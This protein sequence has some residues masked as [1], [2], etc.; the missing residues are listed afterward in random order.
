MSGVTGITTCSLNE[1]INLSV[2]QT[3]GTES[4]EHLGLGRAYIAD[5]SNTIFLLNSS[6]INGEGINLVPSGSLIRLKGFDGSNAIDPV[7]FR[8]ISEAPIEAALAPGD[9]GNTFGINVITNGRINITAD[10]A[11]GGALTNYT[12]ATNLNNIRAEVYLVIQDVSTGVVEICL[13]PNLSL[14]DITQSGDL[15]FSGSSTHQIF[16][17]GSEILNITASNITASNIGAET[18]DIGGF[19]FSS[20]DSLV[21]SGSQVFGDSVTTDTTRFSSSIEFAGN[22]SFKGT[23]SNGTIHANVFSGSGADLNNI[24]MSNTEH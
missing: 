11:V 20:V 22:I 16:A 17:T 3:A 7:D 14:N 15:M 9:V 4:E 18:F 2:N 12:P 23:G 10:T 24:A 8:V 19:N 21:T 1:N 13:D 6:F 5:D